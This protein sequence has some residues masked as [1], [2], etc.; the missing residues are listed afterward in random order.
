M[1][2][3][4]FLSLGCA[5]LTIIIKFSAYY[6]T[7]SIG[8]L[9]DAI[10]SLINL[11]ASIIL[12]VSVIVSQRP[13]DKKHLYGHGKI[14]YLSSGAE[15]ILILIAGSGIICSCIRRS[16]SPYVLMN[17]GYGA[18]LSVVSGGLN[19]MVALLLLKG[20][21]KYDSIALEADAKHLLTDV[22]T[23]IGLGVGLVI[24]YFAPR[25][26][27]FLDPIIGFVLGINIL[28]MGF[29]LIKR[30]FSGLMDHA[31][32]EEEMEILKKIISV[33]KKH[34]LSR[35]HGLKARRSGSK[36]FIEFHLLF[37]GDM[38]VKESHDLCCEIEKEIKKRF[39]GSHVT[40]H[41]EPL[42]DS[43]SWDASEVGG[44]DGI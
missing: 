37:P 34:V 31:L 24:M 2:K 32:P 6:L 8:I 12:V 21:K 11:V 10:E 23:T 36:R 9:S 41:V 22:I 4:A 42:E 17:I 16:L 44:I 39:P 14:E 26:L 3:F 15:G 30:S 13:P 43:K 1:R 28:Y 20:A 40:I 29:C 38:S 19:L 25:K 5:L 7:S 35:W 33:N 27:W 18:V